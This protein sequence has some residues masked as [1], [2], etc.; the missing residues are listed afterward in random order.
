MNNI[1]AK[2][3]LGQ[4]FLKNSNAIARI[5][6]YARIEEHDQIMEIGPG[7]GALTNLLKT[8]TCAKLVLLE[9]DDAFAKL[10][11]IHAEQHNLTHMQII[12]MDALK[13]T[14]QEMQGEWKILGNLPYNV[15]SPMMWDIVSQVPQLKCAVFM[16]QK[17][18]ARRIRAHKDCKEYGGLSVW[19]QSF[20]NVEKGFVLGP[21][22]FSPPPKVDSEV[23]I[24]KPLKAENKPQDPENLSRL[25]KIC[26]QQRRKQLHGI[27]Q[28]A[29]PATYNTGIWDILGMDGSSRAEN[30]SP[31]DFHKLCTLLFPI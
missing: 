31:K 15:A 5:I 23:I 28:K 11:Q 21:Q 8:R 30:L 2:K 18:V 26:F 27:L 25:I 13:Y 6:Q 22:S 16:I 3:S 19:I 17:E 24:L 7:P 1:K 10:H 12:N 29:L 9:K 4:H 14:W 20:C